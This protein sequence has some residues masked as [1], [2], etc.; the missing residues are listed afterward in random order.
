MEVAKGESKAG[1]GSEGKMHTDNLERKPLFLPI[2]CLS[3][4]VSPCSSLFSFPLVNADLHD[5]LVIL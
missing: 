5:D 1:Q 2:A 4:F 3:V